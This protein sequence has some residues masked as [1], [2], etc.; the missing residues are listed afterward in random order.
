MLSVV[1]LRLS[2]PRQMPP[3]R[4]IPIAQGLAAAPT[5]AAEPTA[6]ATI[7]TPKC[8]TKAKASALA[9]RDE[10]PAQASQPAVKKAK[11]GAKTAKP[12]PINNPE[13][14]T[15]LSHKAGFT[16]AQTKSFLD[17]MVCVATSELG[18]SSRCFKFPHFFSMK[19]IV[20][21]AK[22]SAERTCFGKQITTKAKPESIAAKLTLTSQALKK[23]E[24]VVSGSEDPT[25]PDTEVASD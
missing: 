10:G 2:R 20:K 24:A 23:I 5:I 3:K 8:K 4:K 19:L 15:A 25:P 1:P 12:R 14:V 16:M 9:S 17:A 11:T 21:K 22:E 13:I 18:S 7:P 6:E